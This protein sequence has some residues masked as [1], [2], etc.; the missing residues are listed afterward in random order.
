[1]ADVERRPLLRSERVLLRPAE[2]EDLPLF[3]EW[4]NDAD[5]RETL[6]GGA[7]FSSMAEE[8]W[9]EHLQTEQGKTRWHFAI[10]L[11]EDGRP[12]GFGG[13]ESVDVVN[14]KAELGLGIGDRSCWDKGYGTETMAILLDFAFGELRLHRVMLH[15]YQG[16]DRARHVYE[17]VGFVNEGTLR[18]ALYGHG[19]YLDVQVMGIL[20][21]EWLAQDRPRTWQID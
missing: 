9:F 6:G 19:R 15:V 5:V 13:L 14:G 3:V 21:D 20:H 2:R 10:C 7:P 16:N 12:I 18:Q 1:M 4:L 11:R 8:Q 17:K